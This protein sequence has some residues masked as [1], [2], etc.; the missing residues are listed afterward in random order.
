MAI[1]STNA[2][3]VFLA[4]SSAD[5]VEK[6]YDL[7]LILQRAGINVIPGIDEKYD[8]QTY[9]AM[10]A[11]GLERAHCSLHVFSAGYEPVLPSDTSTSV[12]KHQFFEAKKKLAVKPGFKVVAWNSPVANGV[13]VDPRQTNFLNEVRNNIIKN[14]VF[15]NVASPIQLVEDIRSMT[16]VEEKTEFSVS[17]TDIFFICNQLD[18]REANE[19]ADLLSDIIPVE[20]LSIIQDSTIDY[21]ELCV[22]QIGKSKLAVVYFK[23]SA[24]WAIPF[25]QQ[26]WKKI[27][28]ASS[29]IPILLIG[30]EEPDSNSNKTF[31]APKVIS[32]IAA[33]EL[34]PLEIKVEFDR[35][36]EEGIK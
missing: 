26:V 19:I 14:M 6:R 16:E 12:V 32:L 1:I 20:K 34:I 3:T 8:A 29:H 4:F 2:I 11:E 22:Q 13:T 5:A 36:T 23:E 30:D 31:K 7:G 24:D 35:I 21:S 28:G 17:S 10:L 33:G 18:E 9:D 25:V 27:G 15:S